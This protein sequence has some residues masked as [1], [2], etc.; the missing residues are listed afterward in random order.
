MAA[1]RSF[2][3]EILLCLCRGLTIAAMLTLRLHLRPAL[4]TRDIPIYINVNVNPLCMET[5]LSQ[6]PRP[7]H[8]ENR[9][10]TKYETREPQILPRAHILR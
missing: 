5:S 6:F 2:A 3:S 1:C 4:M 9:R 8:A 10:N 7:R